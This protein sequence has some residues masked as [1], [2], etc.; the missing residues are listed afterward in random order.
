[1]YV[2]TY[3]TNTSRSSVLGVLVGVSERLSMCGCGVRSVELY[4][5]TNIRMY[6]V[7]SLQL[8]ISPGLKVASLLL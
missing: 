1:M 8:K 6:I 3:K 7:T 5:H 2:H 4:T